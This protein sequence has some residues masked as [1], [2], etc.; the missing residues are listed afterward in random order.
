MGVWVDGF[1]SNYSLPSSNSERNTMKLKLV[2]KGGPGSGH[3][4]HSGRI[5]KVG[6]SSPGGVRGDASIRGVI[7]KG[8]DERTQRLIGEALSSVPDWNL[9]QLPP[10]LMMRLYVDRI[11]WKGEAA[12][13]LVSDADH[14]LTI[15]VVKSE[16]LGAAE[17]G[18]KA[19]G[20]AHWNG[21]AVSNTLSDTEFKNVVLHELGHHVDNLVATP[22]TRPAPVTRFQLRTGGDRLDGSVSKAGRSLESMLSVYGGGH[23]TYSKAYD[24]YRRL[25]RTVPGRRYTKHSQRGRVEV[26]AEAYSYVAG[27]QGDL[28]PPGVAKG[29]NRYFKKSPPKA[30]R[31]ALQ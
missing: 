4:G 26:F 16:A 3:R 27:G 19:A 14:P 18:R 15:H 24:R 20:S 2:L 21:F 22:R 9:Q 7:I 11:G 8:S 5:G 10:D 13:R 12:D 29:M 6:G 25:F 31:L 23:P 1:V 17:E 28:L 30:V